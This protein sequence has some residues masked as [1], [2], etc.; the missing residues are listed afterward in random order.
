MT[1]DKIDN[2]T[3][4]FF[5]EFVIPEN[6][7][8]FK[9][10]EQSLKGKPIDTLYTKLYEGITTNPIYT[11]GDLQKIQKSNSVQNYLYPFLVDNLQIKTNKNKIELAQTYSYFKPIDV[12]KAILNDL[13]NG[14][15]SIIIKPDYYSSN[16]LNPCKKDEVNIDLNGTSIFSENDFEIIFKKIDFN[17]HAIYLDSSIYPISLASLFLA[18]LKKNKINPDN[19][20][21]GIFYDPFAI[22]L[23]EGQ[24]PY[25]LSTAYLM[26]GQLQKIKRHVPNISTFIIDAKIYNDCGANAVQ[27]LAFSLSTAVQYIRELINQNFSINEI[28]KDAILNFNTGSDFFIGI[29][30]L[31]AARILW[32]KIIKSFGG[33]EISQKVKIF[34]DTC[35]WNKSI[36]E[37]HNNILRNT[38]E[39]MSAIFGGAD[40]INVKYF[41]DNS[42]NPNEFSRRIS[43]NTQLILTDECYLSDVFDPSQGSYYIEW[44]TDN[45][46]RQA[47]ELLQNIEAKGGMLT[48]IQNGY[49]TEQ[50][51]L[52]KSKRI[53]NILTRKDILVGINKFPNIKE[54]FSSIKKSQN[55]YLKRNLVLNKYIEKRNNDDVKNSLEQLSKEQK[56]NSENFLNTAIKVATAGATIEE[57]TYS[58]CEKQIYLINTTIKTFN[59]SKPF[60]ELRKFSQQYKD[61]FGHLPQ[62]FLAKIGNASQY[63]AKADFA[64]DFFMAGGFEPNNHISFETA[65]DAANAFLKSNDKIIVICSSDELYKKTVPEI[66][67]LIK[68]SKPDSNIVLAGYPKENIKEYKAAGVD[69][70]IHINANIYEILSR[71]QKKM[72][73]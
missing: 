23:K 66:C 38:V 8:W 54:E 49:I 64:S 34:A 16:G 65:G 53:D 19:I 24:I 30:K 7:D 21:G 9:V 60:E 52:T 41:D 11:L 68:D 6:E 4:K 12:N 73:F 58:T 36:L 45:L 28:A 13:K 27:E 63:K 69:E 48:C 20:Q 44:F 14:L 35:S 22:L 59:P 47:W 17:N 33:N 55:N 25:S 26:I 31:R 61:K 3:Q 72:I 37:P 50:I 70:F 40:S 56:Q 2:H 57:I 29:A 18:F 1:K 46:A 32:A 43:R 51:N 5:S 71:L 15:N 67:K 10:A 42:A 62:I 39:T